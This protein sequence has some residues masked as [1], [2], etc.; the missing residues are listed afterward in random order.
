M[1]Q[2][3][4]RH[5]PLDIDLGFCCIALQQPLSAGNEHQHITDMLARAKRSGEA[6]DDHHERMCSDLHG[7]HVCYFPVAVPPH[8]PNALPPDAP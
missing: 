8:A 1:D 6:I 2:D 7:K 3:N 5:E 4:P